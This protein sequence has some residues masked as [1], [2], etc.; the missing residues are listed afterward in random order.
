L[1]VRTILPYSITYASGNVTTNTFDAANRLTQA[2][3]KSSSGATLNTWQYGFDPAGNM[4]SKT[5]NGTTTTLAYNA[6]NEMT[7]AG[8]T[9]YS[10][11]ATGA[12]TGSSAGENISYNSAQ[13]TTSLTPAGGEVTRI[14]WTGLD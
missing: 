2:V 14:L 1:G 7:A 5:A 9:T 4:T 8:S 11:D 6:A 12:Q 10:Y 13:Q 3:Q